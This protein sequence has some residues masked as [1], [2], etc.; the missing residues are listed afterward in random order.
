MI[1]VKKK[2]ALGKVIHLTMPNL[3]HIIMF[4][5]CLTFGIVIYEGIIVS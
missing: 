1:C 3:E 5:T 2:L 4:H